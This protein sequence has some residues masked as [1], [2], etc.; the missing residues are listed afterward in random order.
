MKVMVEGLTLERR[1]GLIAIEGISEVLV[2][3]NEVLL[4]PVGAE[5][6]PSVTVEIQTNADNLVKEVEAAVEKC[7]ALDKT[8]KPATKRGRPKAAKASAKEK[9]PAP[10]KDRTLDPMPAP[11]EVAIETLKAIHELGGGTGAEIAKHCDISLEAALARITKLRINDLVVA[12]GVRPKKW[13]LT[14]KGRDALGD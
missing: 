4:L 2:R 10:K 8:K 6:S 1:D 13:K 14:G 9:N 7:G 12:T 3:G 5:Y 11:G